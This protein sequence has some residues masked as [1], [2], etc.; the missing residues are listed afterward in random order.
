MQKYAIFN[1]AEE[2]VRN[3]IKIAVAGTGYVGLS[4]SILLAQHHH[5]TAV[6]IV[7]EKVEIVNKRQSPIQ[8]EYIEKYLAEKELDLTAT[9][10]AESAYKDADFVIIA[11]PT[12]YNSQKNFF[13]TSA[14]ESVIRLVANYNPDAIIVIK[15]TIPV[16]FTAS[17]RAKYHYENIIFSSEFLRE[18]KA[19]Y[20]NLYPS[21]IVVGT[22]L[23]DARLVKAAN[24]FAGLL[25]E[26]AIKENIETLIMDFT[27]AEAVKLFSNTYL[28]LRV[29]YFNE[30]D[31]YAE[32]KGLNTKQIIEGVCLDPR[33][34]G[35][36]NNP[37]FGYGGYC[38]P[39]DTKQLLACYENVP[40]N[41]IEAIVQ[42]NYTRKDFIA[43]R[44]LEIA[45]AEHDPVKDH[46]IVIG[47][48]RLAMKVNMAAPRVALTEYRC[49]IFK[50]RSFFQDGDYYY[51]NTAGEVAQ[52]LMDFLKKHT[53]YDTDLIF[54]NMLRTANQFDLVRT[55]GLHYVLPCE[56]QLAEKVHCKTA[57]LI[58]AYYMDQMERTCQ[59]AAAMPEDADIYIT[60]PHREQLEEIKKVFS[61]LPNKVEIRL[62]E[63][64]GRDVS[65]LLIGF[66]DLMNQYD[67]FC[68]YHDKKSDQISPKSIENS[69]CYL[70]SEST[71][72][73][74]AYVQNILNT[75]EE[76]PRL[77]ML[78]PVP[79]CHSDYYYTLCHDWGPNYD[80]TVKLKE[81]LN[82][83]VPISKDKPPV[84]PMGTAFWFRGTAMKKLFSRKWEYTDFP[85]EPT[86]VDGTFLHAVERIYPYVV[87]DAGY[88]P[89]YVMPDFIA[90]MELNMMTYYLRSFNKVFCENNIYGKQIDI[91]NQLKS[92]LSGNGFSALLAA[93]P[94]GVKEALKIAINKRLPFLFRKTAARFP[95]NVRSIGLRDAINI[96]RI[97]RIFRKY[98]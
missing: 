98:N 82:L 2:E 52:D 44:V 24:A 25:Q 93:P 29:A 80:N 5:V 63:N 33:I 96:W 47:V 94:F 69:F 90:S 61:N 86:G 9:L 79:P 84:A 92:R 81:Q 89:A 41:L 50:R 15:S 27:E 74:K 88:Y 4:I 65:S 73:G 32:M 67:Y 70:V 14:V 97:K 20:D 23:E 48:Y 56:N 46:S 31:T 77:G 7:P 16:G 35:H 38:L 22:G 76:N 17:V 51:C 18:S 1:L 83:N 91:R 66:A 42:S 57:L 37:S 62:I 39:K 60:T 68:F 28:A 3:K 95:T 53:D 49:P 59:Y 8:D 45:G 43:N 75:F 72:H 55:L 19:L 40:E 78:S 12:N 64:R 30:L 87:Q 26:G 34:G 36:Y 13:D 54:E 11:A 58:H 10:D 6:D 21:R 71:L 85:A